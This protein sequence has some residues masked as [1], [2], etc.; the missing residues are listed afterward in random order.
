MTTNKILVTHEN[1]T[2]RKK[3]NEH[4]MCNKKKK[5]K[6]PTK[7]VELHTLVHVTKKIQRTLQE[8]TP[9]M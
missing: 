4:K 3:T 1:K 6:M 2:K 9:S 7:L 8:K 5:R